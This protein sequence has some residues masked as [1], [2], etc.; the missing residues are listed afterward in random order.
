MST[1]DTGAVR[2]ALK[3][4]ERL[5]EL[6]EHI[7][8]AQQ[9]MREHAQ[10]MVKDGTKAIFAEYGDIVHSF[11]W[12]QYT[13][14]FNDG[15]PCEFGMHELV[16]VAHEDLEGLDEFEAEE[17]RSEW[18]YEGSPTFSHYGSDTKVRE[19]FYGG[20]TN[21]NF[22]QRYKDAYDAC[23]AIYEALASDGQKLARDVFGDHVEVIFTPQGVDVQEYEHD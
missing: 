18:R 23:V 6:S 21:P 16:V 19:T 10:E 7:K 9:Q 3:P 14:Y 17:R 11:G 12:L 22:D 20:D 13:P 5:L 1:M 8:R 15:E 4:T 2:E